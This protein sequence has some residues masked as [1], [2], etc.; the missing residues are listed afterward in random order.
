MAAVMAAMLA[1]VVAALLAAMLAVVLTAMMAVVPDV[2]A[3][4][5]VAVLATMAAAVLAAVMAAELAAV[6]RTSMT[7][8]LPVADVLLAVMAVLAGGLAVRLAVILLLHSCCNFRFLA[9]A[10]ALFR[11]GVARSI[12]SS[13]SNRSISPRN[14]SCSPHERS[15]HEGGVPTKPMHD[16]GSPVR[17]LTRQQ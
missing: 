8:G 3:V 2:V 14:A 7:A 15:S 6:M 10:V 17:H 11:F 12:A 5:L 9:C 13:T 16:G 4:L 1:A